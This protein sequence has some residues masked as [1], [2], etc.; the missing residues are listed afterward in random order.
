MIKYA[1]N[2]SKH[3]KTQNKD[4][5]MNSQIHKW[6]KQNMTDMTQFR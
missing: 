4:K 5:K 3:F 1:C 2:V 6:I